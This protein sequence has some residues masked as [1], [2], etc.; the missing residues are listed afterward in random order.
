MA[1][2][3]WYEKDYDE[4]PFDDCDWDFLYVLLDIISFLLIVMVIIFAVLE[5]N[6]QGYF[7]AS[8]NKLPEVIIRI[9]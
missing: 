9:N 7:T 4:N 2:K 6:A 5:L 1:K 8:I 3:H